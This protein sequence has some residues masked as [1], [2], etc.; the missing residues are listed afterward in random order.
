VG[1][2]RF[3]LPPDDY[4]QYHPERYVPYRLLWAKVIIRAAYDFA[5]WK[6]SKDIRL[7]NYAKDAERWLFDES[8]LM[9]SF[10]R[11]CEVLNIDRHRIR[12]Y[13]RNLTRDQVKKLEFM[14]REGRDMIRE[15]AL[16]GRIRDADGDSR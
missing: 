11:I 4:H 12:E 10:S 13:A 16:G 5:L 1:A 3:K 7:R 6:D 9:N 14:E 8:T 15:I 2:Q